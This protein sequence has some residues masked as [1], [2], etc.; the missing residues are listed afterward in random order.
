VPTESDYEKAKGLWLAAAKDDEVRKMASSGG[1]TRVLI[2]YVLNSGICD[3][4]YSLI[5]PL[6]ES[7]EARGT[8]LTCMP[9]NK[10]IPCSLYR[11]VLWGDSLADF[12]ENW[13]NILLVGLPCQLKA[14]KKL[15]NRLDKNLNIFSISIY[16]RKQKNFGYTAYIKRLS[17]IPQC[18]NV[19]VVYRG[20]GWPGVL[21]ISKNSQFIG[22]EFFYPASCW[23]LKGCLFC[24]DYLNSEDS[25]IT[26]RDPWGLISPQKEKLGQNLV[27]A[28]TQAG[29][30]LLTKAEKLLEINPVNLESVLRFEDFESLKIKQEARRFYL[31][32]DIGFKSK[33]CFH[34][35]DIYTRLAEIQLYYLHH[36]SLLIKWFDYIKDHCSRLIRGH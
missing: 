10:R 23:N 35:K 13:S 16:C 22:R 6:H 34:M 27:M 9:D 29:Q 20:A 1:V 8:W 7:E 28:W 21:G 4:V 26:V 19:H 11:P 17:G 31:G 32:E 36:D 15:L 25:D 14:G 30:T 3:A 33:I 24:T 18:D 2:Q 5:Y 12:K